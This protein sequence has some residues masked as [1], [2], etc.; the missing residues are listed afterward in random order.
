[1]QQARVAVHILY[2]VVAHLYRPLRVDVEHA[3]LRGVDDRLVKLRDHALVA[4]LLYRLGRDV[5]GVRDCVL[6]GTYKLAGK[7][8]LAREADRRVAADERVAAVGD[9]SVDA[10]LELREGVHGVQGYL[11]VHEAAQS[12][13]LV[14][15]FVKSAYRDMLRAEV[16]AALRERAHDVVA[17]NRQVDEGH[18]RQY[19]AHALRRQPAR[20]DHVV[21]VHVLRGDLV[22]GHYPYLHIY[23]APARVA[24]EDVFNGIA[25]LGV[26]G[27]EQYAHSASLLCGGM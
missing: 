2:D 5:D 22:D 1:M 15:L 3:V 9:R 14:Y 12:L 17:G 26:G 21:G 20:D 16:A 23:V 25:E 7:A 19:R 8:A 18:L 11:A 24:A 10:P 13:R 6:A 4:N 27:D